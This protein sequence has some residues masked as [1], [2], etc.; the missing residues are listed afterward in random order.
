MEKSLMNSGDEHSP[1]I[2]LTTRQATYRDK[3]QTTQMLQ[4]EGKLTR[5][6]GLTLEA[7][8]FSAAIGSRCLVTTQAGG[9]I[10]AEVVGFAD[11]K[12]FLMPVT[13]P[14]GLA[15]GC[16]IVAT[17][18][19]AQ[20]TVS[21]DLLGRVI[22]G[23]GHPLDQLGQLTSAARIPLLGARMNP[24]TRHAMSEPLDVGIRAI[25]GLLTVG[26]GQRLGLFSNA[27]V[28]KTTL[29]SMMTRFTSADVVVIGLIG[30]RGHDIKEFVE[31][32]LGPEGLQRAVVVAVSADE[33]P[34]ARLHGALRATS[35]AEY[36]RDQGKDV[37]LLMDSMTHV[38]Q[39]Q[40]EISLAIGEQPACNGYPPS[41]FA[42]LS[43]LVERAGH[44]AVGHGSIT[45]MYT[46]LTQGQD[47]QDPIVGAARAMLDGQIVLSRGLADN[48]HYPAI[49][50]DVSLSRAMSMVTALEH[51][52]LTRQFKRLYRKYQQNKDLIRM[53]A[54]VRGSDPE[55]E[56]AIACY[57]M[58]EK[59]LQQGT[60]DNVNYLHSVAALRRVFSLEPA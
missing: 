10:S 19:Q 11:D 24:L 31:Q 30:E 18:Q 9:V 7:V 52:E 20:V 51:Q 5:V 29:L 16:K 53:G 43:Q 21:P 57:P 32:Y 34:L 60:N 47:D 28:G 38:A 27:G 42:R 54:Y 6:V 4:V 48:A 45:A 17:D 56:Q 58:M 40:R 2:P 59:Y 49:D 1:H 41:V 22:D 33:P 50:I 37:L 26:R 25:N 44:A 3:I 36:F 8:G 14:H 35:I 13:H 55:L 23:S 39:A 46:V 12:T 15:P